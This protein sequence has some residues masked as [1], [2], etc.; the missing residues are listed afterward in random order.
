MSFIIE[1]TLNRLGHEKWTIENGKAVYHEHA[2]ILKVL[3]YKM[4]SFEATKRLDFWNNLMA[5]HMSRLEKILVRFQEINSLRSNNL[6]KDSK[7]SM[8]C[9]LCLF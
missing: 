8:K 3:G 2:Q 4:G 5:C 9:L 6:E 7:K 1:N